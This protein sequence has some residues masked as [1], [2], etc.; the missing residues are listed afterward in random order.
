MKILIHITLLL[1]PLNTYATVNYEFIEFTFALEEVGIFT[2]D[3]AFDL[4][5]NELI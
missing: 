4:I 2:S 1:L 3:E 5:F